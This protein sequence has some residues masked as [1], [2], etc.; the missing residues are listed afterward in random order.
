MV[1]DGKQKQNFKYQFY[2][3]KWKKKFSKIQPTNHYFPIINQKSLILWNASD[4]IK[5]TL[6]ST[7]Q[8]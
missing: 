2:I 5:I 8:S 4:I 3:G 1:Y 7:T 6:P